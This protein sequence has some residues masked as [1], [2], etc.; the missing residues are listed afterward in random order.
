M[1]SRKPETDGY[2]TD[3]E[4]IEKLARAVAAHIPAQIPVDIALW[5]SADCAAFMRISKTHFMQYVAP[6]PGFPHAIRIPK[7]DG[8]TGQP[9]WKA[10][11]VIE[12]ADGYQEKRAA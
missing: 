4:L 10:K 7:S 1:G 8:K 5:D 12:W 3:P 11:E 2:M 9:R 6:Q